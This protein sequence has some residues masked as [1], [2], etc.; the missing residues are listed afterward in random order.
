MSSE[1]APRRSRAEA[2]ILLGAAAVVYLADQV[3]KAIVVSS[4]AM[5]ERIDV[6]GDILQIWHAENHG[7]A[8][9]LLQGGQLLFLVVSVIAL[10]VIGYFFRAL[11]GRSLWL[12]A[13]LGI[14]LG[15][16]LG[17]LV[18]RVT[19]GGFVTDWISVG[20]GRTRWPTFNIADASID[21][22]I[23]LLIVVLTLADRARAPRPRAEA[24]R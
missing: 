24:G 6:I 8:F 20:I 4:V 18:D 10:A 2:G 9:S 1:P 22:G 23:I 12:Y 16:T 5:G 13:L 17:N 14:I 21:T 15:G 3:T 11:H 19:R 7:A